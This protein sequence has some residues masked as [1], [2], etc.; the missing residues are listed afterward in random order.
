MDLPGE[1]W[2]FLLNR[3]QEKQLKTKVL[4]LVGKKEKMPSKAVNQSQGMRVGMGEGVGTGIAEDSMKLGISGTI[5]CGQPCIS[6]LK[7]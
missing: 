1:C 4:R 6:V 2:R 3:N 7:W 5:F